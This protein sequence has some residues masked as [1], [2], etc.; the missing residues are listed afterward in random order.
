MP[1]KDTDKIPFELIADAVRCGL[2]R[3]GKT[4]DMIEKAKGSEGELSQQKFRDEFVWHNKRDLELF[5]ADMLKLDPAAV[6]GP[7][8]RTSDFSS[9]ISAEIGK[10]R[11][12]GVIQDWHKGMG[13]W[14][15]T[16]PL[17]MQPPQLQASMEDYNPQKKY[18]NAGSAATESEMRKVFV[19][20]LSRGPKDNTYKFALARAILEHCHGTRT[21][22]DSAY[23]ISYRHLARCFLKY[24]WRQESV[25]KIRQTF[26]RKRTPRAIQAIGE[27]FDSSTPG[28]FEKL[29]ADDIIRAEDL[30][31]KTVFGHARTKTSLVVPKFQNIKVGQRVRREAIFY[32]YD[33]DAKYI[34]LRPEAFAFFKQ[35]YD[36]L[37]RVVLAEWT[38]FLEKVNT[39]PRLMMKVED[40]RVKR[41]PMTQYRKL[42]EDHFDHCFYCCN[43]LER[44]YTDVDHFIPWSYIFEDDLWNLVL[45]CRGCN[46]KKSASLA[47]EEFLELL[48][49][50][51]ST[52]HTRM[53]SLENSLHYLSVKSDGWKR[54]INN[55]YYTCRDYGFTPIS[56]P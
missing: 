18:D 55:H 19:N 50:R 6:M 35:N 32:E 7:R 38:R 43:R 11:R 54:G 20:I 2:T 5:V 14:R 4:I 26:D 16:E 10:L 21:G 33:D 49:K 1:T 3:K 17:K 40:A 28:I 9:A 47:G 36:L 39:M 53:E 48:I 29:D 45:A 23:H 27:I 8:R 15:L 56:L 31:M 52:Y 34:Y 24:Y 42:L 30:I 46:H 51:N 22:R 25:F 44:E 37:R 41:G 12:K 13:V